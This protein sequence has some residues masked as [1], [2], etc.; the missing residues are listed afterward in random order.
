MKILCAI[1]LVA[2]LGVSGCH[3]PEADV[4]ER[5]VDVD[6]GGHRLHMLI[7]GERGP[8]VVLESGLGGG[9]G[10]K[11]VRSEVG[12]FARAVTYDR[13]GFGKSEPGPRPR[14]AEQIAIELRTA[15]GNA[16]LCPPYILVGHS[17]G[18]PYVRVF[19]ARHPQEVSGIVLVDPTQINRY[20]SLAEIREWFAARSP[21]DWERVEASCKHM[22]AGLEWMAALDAKRLEVYL[23]SVPQPRRESLRS[24]LTA[25]AQSS[26]PKQSSAT[27]PPSVKA[28]FE[29]AADS[30]K[31]A[32][33]A[34]PL[35]DVPIIV[36]GAW[37]PSSPSAVAAALNPDLRALQ[38]EIQGWHLRDYREWVAATP[39]A[40]LVVARNCG[41]NIQLDNPGLV[42]GAIREVAG[43]SKD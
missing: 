4:P 11:Q 1:A 23:D 35:P 41:H 32:I 40:R 14:T 12:R 15:L 30:F 29:A 34:T 25:L 21:N 36:L 20:E 6:A 19:A 24:E 28:E 37:Q 42:V 7:A 9:V 10:W 26:S 18:G 2:L 13:A 3:R 38:Q 8:T 17:M 5:S 33:A 39:G 16:G 31:Q 27:S 22:A 43:H